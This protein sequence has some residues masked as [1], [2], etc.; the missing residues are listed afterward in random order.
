MTH[1]PRPSDSDPFFQLLTDALRAGPG[2][3]QWGEA[4]AKLRDGG[5]D[6]ADEY[7]LIIRAREDLE[8]RPRLPPVTAGPGFT[9]KVLDAV[10]QE[11]GRRRTASRPRRIIAILAGLGD[12]RRDRHRHRHHEPRRAAA[13]T[14]P[15]AAIERS[16]R[17]ASPVAVA[18]GSVPRPAADGLADASGAGAATRPTAAVTRGRD[19]R[20]VI[21]GGW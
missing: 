14:P 19:W 21:G 15:Q 13:R 16:K 4:V 9:R 20:D 1:A 17:Q 5:V 11:G 10:E 2:S 3:A 7:R 6:G 18:S 12:P 8:Q